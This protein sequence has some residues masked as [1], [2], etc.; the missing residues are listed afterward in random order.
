MAENIARVGFHPTFLSL[1]D[2]SGS[3]LS[4]VS[5]LEAEG[6]NTKYIG[7]TPDGMGT[8]LA[9]FDHTGEVVASLSKRPNYQPLAEIIQRHGKKSSRIATASFWRSI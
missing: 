8:W 2:N 9:I 6:I 4:V 5:R 7:T 1:V 3:A